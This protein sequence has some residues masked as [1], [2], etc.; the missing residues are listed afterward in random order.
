MPLAADANPIASFLYLNLAPWRI[1]SFN[2]FS[3]GSLELNS[4]H[5]TGLTV[6]QVWE[7]GRHGWH[8]FDRR[9][10]QL[11][12]PLTPPGRFSARFHYAGWEAVVPLREVLFI[13]N[14]MVSAVLGMAMR[15]Q[16]LQV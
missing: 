4:T 3:D 9:D 1:H 2:L 15:S 12:A 6:W 16:S 13:Y 10:P 11:N 5:Q 8:D 7:S 14:A